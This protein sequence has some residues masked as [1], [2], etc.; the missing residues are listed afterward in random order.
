MA[1]PLKILLVSVSVFT[2]LNRRPTYSVPHIMNLLKWSLKPTETSVKA[3]IAQF[4]RAT[5]TWALMDPTRRLTTFV[6]WRI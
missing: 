6:R 5:L 1:L 4:S 2:A 3:L